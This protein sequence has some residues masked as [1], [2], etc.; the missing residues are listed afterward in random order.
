MN[1]V[2]TLPTLPNFVG[3][4][5][6]ESTSE[7]RLVVTN[8]ATGEGIAEVPL[9]TA[10]DLDVAVERAAA[11]QVA[12][13]KTPIKDRVQ[14]LF[15]MKTL[16]EAQVDHLAKKITEENGKSDAEARGSI[17]RAIEC[18]EYA[19]SLPQIV[20]GPRLE[21]SPG[22]ECR[23]IRCPLGVTAGI[24]PFNFPLMVPL[25]MAPNAIACGNAF[26]LKP[27]EQTPQSALEIARLFD[28]AG[29]PPGI[30][31]VVHGDR[32]V[33]EAIC[34]HPKIAA[35][36]FVG[37][38]AVAKA[39]YERGCAH[40]KRVRALGGARTTWWWCPMRIPR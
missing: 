40:Y 21:V 15:R 16:M 9:S 26:I 38:T 4:A 39:V 28:E 13:G 11:A 7:R 23:M 18:V 27:S 2:G 33:V 8:P 17:L 5:P 3:G 14:V 32:A 31:S 12:W 22:V 25:W 10:A 37:S 20:G 6:L 29:L 30:F 19:S 34:D 35:I 36:A 1:P 24:T